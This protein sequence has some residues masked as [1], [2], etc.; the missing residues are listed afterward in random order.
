MAQILL[1][2]LTC[3][4]NLPHKVHDSLHIKFTHKK[5]SIPNI[6]NATGYNFMWWAHQGSCLFYQVPQTKGSRLS[7]HKWRRARSRYFCCET[8]I[9]FGF[10]ITISSARGD[11]HSMKEP[12]ERFSSN[13]KVTSLYSSSILSL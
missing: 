1:I 6:E 2:Y 11:L 13:C 8:H 9:Y 7:M 4:L 3:N 12:Q 10:I 5:V